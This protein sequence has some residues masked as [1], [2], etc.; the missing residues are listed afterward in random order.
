MLQ[1]ADQ[2]PKDPRLFGIRDTSVHALLHSDRQYLG[3]GHVVQ[4]DPP[5][6]A[7]VHLDGMHARRGSHLVGDRQHTS[8]V[9][10][11]S[12]IEVRLDLR[13]LQL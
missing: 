8:E 5:Q 10:L 12:D 4:R 1:V 13:A 11:T 3:P 9:V 7:A 6:L 2:L